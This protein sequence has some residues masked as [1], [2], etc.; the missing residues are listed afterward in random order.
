M[1]GLRLIIETDSQQVCHK[2]KASALDFSPTDDF[3][4]LIK[5]HFLECPNIECVTYANRKTNLLAHSLA[6]LG[7]M[8]SAHQLLF[9]DLPHQLIP[10]VMYDIS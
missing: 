4:R 7:A 10:I 8:L 2:V 1:A 5:S 3:T 6:H 9:Q